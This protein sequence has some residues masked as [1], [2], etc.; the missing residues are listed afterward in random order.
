MYADTQVSDLDHKP[1]TVNELKDQYEKLFSVNENINK[2]RSY[3]E[4][5]SKNSAD[6]K[7]C[8]CFSIYG[9]CFLLTLYD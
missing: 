3:T 5:I 8:Y 4:M 9:C 7:S 6:C 2:K 1:A